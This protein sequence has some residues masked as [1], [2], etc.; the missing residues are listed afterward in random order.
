MSQNVF[1][2]S[3]DTISY[4]CYITF[5]KYLITLLEAHMNQSES[6]VKALREQKGLT[7]GDLASAVGVRQVQISHIESGRRKPSL[8]V[9]IKLAQIFGVSVET[10]YNGLPEKVHA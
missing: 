7:Q 1:T 10:L 2:L 9:A 4:R 5:S 6:T 8:K 3:I